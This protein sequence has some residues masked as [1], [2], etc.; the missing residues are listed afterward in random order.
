MT[1]HIANKDGWLRISGSGGQ[2]AVAG[3]PAFFK[4][5]EVEGGDGVSVGWDW[6][7]ERL[8]ARTCAT[9]F[10]PLYYYFDG[11]QIALATR[12]A[13][14][15]EATGTAPEICPASL[16]VLLRLGFLVGNRTP[17]AR[18]MVLGPQGTLTW[19]PGSAPEVRWSYPAP[20]RSLASGDIRATYVELFRASM[21]RIAAVMSDEVAVPLSGGRDSRHIA[22]E[23]HRSGRKPRFA[24]TARHLPPRNDEDVRVAAE[25]CNAMGWTHRVVGQPVSGRFRQECAH[26]RAVDFLTFEHAWTL[27]V[28]DAI[29]AGGI[30]EVFDGVGGDVLSASLYQDDR[31]LRHYFDA[32]IEGVRNRLLAFW[33]QLGGDDALNESLGA[34][35]S[36]LRERGAALEL[37]DAELRLHQDHPNPLK[38]FYFWN[39]SRRS[40][41]LLPFRIFGEAVA[42]A[43]YLDAPLMKFLLGLDPGATRD[44]TLHTDAIRLADPRI[45]AIA[46]EDKAARA[47]TQRISDRVSFYGPMIAGS[48]KARQFVNARFVAPRAAR[49]LL[50]GGDLQSTWWKPRRVAYLASL[51]QFVNQFNRDTTQQRMAHYA[52][53]DR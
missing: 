34:A 50:L 25:L 11:A 24:V 29:R 48:L 4:G 31:L 47:A 28:R 45:G 44:R 2:L 33:S 36:A 13:D 19:R 26:A 14:L 20:D 42:Y 52:F 21:A 12:I 49:S 35:L 1:R 32:D 23:L 18:V 5:Y 17:F 46:Y 6:D 7:G 16:G 8:C 41:G 22:L 9:G 40:T 10:M 37:I 30:T 15:F 51:H 43:P 38:A 3:Q 27:P 39:R 53:D